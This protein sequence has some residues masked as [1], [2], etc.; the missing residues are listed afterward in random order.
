MV[1]RGTQYGADKDIVFAAGNTIPVGSPFTGTFSGTGHTTMF[2]VV[3][4]TGGGNYRA[5]S[6]FYACDAHDVPAVAIGIDVN[7]VDQIALQF[8]VPTAGT[9]YNF[10]VNYSLNYVVDGQ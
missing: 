10:S 8:R 9:A 2:R 4:P 6:D 5:L 1:W 7:G 3:T